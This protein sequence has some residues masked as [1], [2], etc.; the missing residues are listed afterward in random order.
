MLRAAFVQL[1]APVGAGWRVSEVGIAEGEGGYFP[2]LMVHHE[3]PAKG[4][5]GGQRT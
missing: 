2:H 4:G 3:P 1:L 5:G